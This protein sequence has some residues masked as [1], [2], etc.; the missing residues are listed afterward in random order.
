MTNITSQYLPAMNALNNFYAMLY[1]ALSLEMPDGFLSTTGAYVW[2]GYRIDSYKNL[3]ACQYY[4]QIYSDD[5]EILLFQESFLTKGH[6][7]HHE[8]GR[9]INLVEED[10]FSKVREDQL[11]FLRDFVKS[12]LSEA[13]IWQDSEE[14]KVIVP[15]KFISGGKINRHK[16]NGKKSFEKVSEDFIHAIPMQKG[17]FDLLCKAIRSAS[18]SIYSKKVQLRPNASWYNFD[19][20]GYRMKFINPQGKASVGPSDYVWRIYFKEPNILSCENKNKYDS[21]PMPSFQISKE[22]L[23]GSE[24]E[25]LERLTQYTTQCLQIR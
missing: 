9:V 8:L 3:A 2:R 12:A 22:F 7:F 13:L 14:R 11:Y 16:L 24:V 20:R 1:D 23:S 19:F 4:C 25:K 5:P 6:Y 15:K 21:P 10:F 18:E 17:I